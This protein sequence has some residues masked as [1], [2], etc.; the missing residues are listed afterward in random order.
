MAIEGD[1]A[2]LQNA[3]GFGLVLAAGVVD[4]QAVLP[5]YLVGRAEGLRGFVGIFRQ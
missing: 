2:E 3:G 4:A 5:Q 1:P